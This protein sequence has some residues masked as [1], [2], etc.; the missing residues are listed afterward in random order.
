MGDGSLNRVKLVTDST[1]DLPPEMAREHGITVVPLQVIF[2]SESLRDGIDIGGARFYERLASDPTPARTSQPSPGDFVEAY[3]RLGRDGS[4]IVSVH[5]SSALS[6]T[7]QSAEVARQNCPELEI[8]TIDTRSVSLGLGL[9]VLAAARAARA[10]GSPGE[11]AA[12]ARRVADK[13]AIAFTVDTLE[14]LARNGRIGKAQAFLGSLLSIKPVLQVEDGVV[15]PVDRV[16]G[17]G[18]AL[19]RIVD[20]LSGRVAPGPGVR[21]AVM[22][23]RAE[24]DAAALADRLRQVYPGAEV[25]TGELGA[26][27]GTHAGP[28][29]VGVCAYRDSSPSQG[30]A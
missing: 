14:F 17:R 28:G 25:L 19:E 5:I 11:V 29:T 24:A 30:V 9:A 1:A 2:G 8:H 7:F 16:R 12:V 23:A 4:A 3:R 26:V 21:A 27:V 15:S 20:V 22:H 10:G 6:G 18:K 13:M